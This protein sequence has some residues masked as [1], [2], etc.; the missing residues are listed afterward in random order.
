MIKIEVVIRP[1]NGDVSDPIVGTIKFT[2]N[3]ELAI[4][5]IEEAMS[6]IASH[7]RPGNWSYEEGGV[8]HA[9]TDEIKFAEAKFIFAQDPTQ[10]EMRVASRTIADDMV[11]V[12]LEADMSSADFLRRMESPSR[13][14]GE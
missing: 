3:G 9:S 14:K 6:R 1:S 12:C 8:I 4:G 5:L 13:P 2:E 7:S 11:V 10:P